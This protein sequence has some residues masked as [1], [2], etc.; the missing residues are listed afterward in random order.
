MSWGVDQVQHIGLAILGRIFDPH[1]VGLDRDAPFTFNIHTV[2]HLRFHIARS[3]R[4]RQLNETVGK[5]GFPVVNMRH[6]GEI[7]D[8]I[9]LC[10]WAHIACP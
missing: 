8:L 5:C 4:A 7:S 1:R 9:K 3:D 2:K 10:H 6:D